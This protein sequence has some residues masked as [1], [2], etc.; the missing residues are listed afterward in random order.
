MVEK[1]SKPVDFALDEVP[2]VDKKLSYNFEAYQG[3]KVKIAK[4]EIKDEINFF[5][6]GKN[7]DDQSKDRCFRLY[8]ISEP[9]K[10]LDDKGN[11]TDKMVE[12][13]QEDGSMK[14]LTVRAR[15]NLNTSKDGKPEISK[16][17][18]AKL[19]AAMRKLGATKLSEML[20]KL[21]MIDLELSKVEGDDR[22][23][24]RLAI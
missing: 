5:P 10:V 24:L 11:F 22:K 15:F 2:V 12:I 4:V 6:D 17:P 9:L 18:K 21:V 20:G 19:W 7:Y 1:D 13:P 3:K 8:V 16:H 14:Q 23:Y